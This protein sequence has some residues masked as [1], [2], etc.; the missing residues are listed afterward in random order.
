M[1]FLSCFTMTRGIGTRGGLADKWLGGALG[2]GID[3]NIQDVYRFLCLNYVDGDQV[4]LLGFSRGAYTVRSLA[5]MIYCSGLLPHDKI[6]VTKAAYDLYRGDATPSSDDAVAFR[7]DNNSRQIDI[8]LV[9]CWDT[10]GSLGIPRRFGIFPNK[11]YEFHDVKLNRKIRHALHAIAID[12]RRRPFDVTH[13]EQ[14][15][16]ADSKIMEAWFPGTHGCVGGGTKSLEPLSNEALL[17]MI[18]QIQALNLGLKFS[19][20][21]LEALKTDHCAPFSNDLGFYKLLGAIN[22]NID[23]VHKL[24]TSVKHRYRDVTDYRPVELEKSTFKEYL[25][26]FVGNVMDT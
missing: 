22:R 2:W 13:M 19:Q 3:Q 20:T 8:T 9:G 1:A 21:R 15:E 7:R 17:W 23:S 16:A 24:H 6:T 18:G 26:E 25:E 14:S 5:G 12:E 10:V 4:Y 11:K